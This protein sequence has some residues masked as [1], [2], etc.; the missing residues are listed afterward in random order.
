M[1]TLP[2]LN[3]K[4]DLSAKKGVDVGLESVFNTMNGFWSFAEMSTWK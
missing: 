3:A 1:K 2:Y 4:S